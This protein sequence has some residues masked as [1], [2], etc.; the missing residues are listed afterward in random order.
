VVG[1]ARGERIV[2]VQRAPEYAGRSVDRT[3]E[4]QA[5]REIQEYLHDL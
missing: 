1:D 4:G 3:S 5:T 2:L